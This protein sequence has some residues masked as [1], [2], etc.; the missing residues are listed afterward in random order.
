MTV[1][2]VVFLNDEEPSAL[3]RL[4]EA[5]DNPLLVN[6]R[7]QSDDVLTTVDEVWD[8]VAAHP[9]YVEAVRELVAEGGEGLDPVRFARVAEAYSA[10]AVLDGT[11]ASAGKA[12]GDA[13]EEL[14]AANPKR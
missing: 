5:W 9:E 10:Y 3:D 13:V 11:L 4:R 2:T 14:L 8:Q 1:T 7:L 12:L 6:P